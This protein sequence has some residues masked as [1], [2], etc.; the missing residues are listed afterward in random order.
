MDME[1]KR[2]EPTMSGM[3]QLGVKGLLR[4]GVIFSILWLL[5]IGVAIAIPPK[6][7]PSQGREQPTREADL[8]NR[9]ARLEA[10]CGAAKPPDAPDQKAP[11]F[12]SQ[13][14]TAEYSVIMA[15]ISTWASLQYALFPIL[16]AAFAILSKMDNWP[17]NLRLWAA[18]GVL[19]A[20][21]LA[22]QGTMLD[23]LQNV[24]LIERYLRPLASRLVGTDQ[25]WIHERFYR[26]S[27]PVNVFYWKYW[28]PLICLSAL[29]GVMWYIRSRHG[30]GRKDYALA[31]IA[32]VAWVGVFVLTAEGSRLEAQIIETC[33][34][35]N[36]ADP[37]QKSHKSDRPTPAVERMD[38][39]L[40]A[41]HR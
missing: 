19:F 28:P 16:L 11:Q 15:R 9:M 27:Y 25:F 37:I 14:Y 2:K 38:T 30:F 39:A 6:T 4:W 41:A 10:L 32:L 20:G 21:Y 23:E 13:Y 7:A 26:Q 35:S 5:A 3:A 24:L 17:A 1:P 8:A 31:A 22:Y 18:I 12:L 36:L 40:P 33:K 29:A 34:R